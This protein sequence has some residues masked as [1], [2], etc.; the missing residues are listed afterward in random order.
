MTNQIKEGESLL[1]FGNEAFSK[2]GRESKYR[3]LGDI[4]MPI[5]E[6]IVARK[7]VSTKEIYRAKEIAKNIFDK[8]FNKRESKE[9]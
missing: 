4:Y 8:E 3:T 2:L 1:S 7:N 5:I 9:C 6:K